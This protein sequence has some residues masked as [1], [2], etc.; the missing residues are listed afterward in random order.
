MVVD[1]ARTSGDRFSLGHLLCA[2]AIGLPE[3]LPWWISSWFG[4]EL[5]IVAG[6]TTVE[7]EVAGRTEL[8]CLCC[9]SFLVWGD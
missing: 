4:A 7:T 8:G 1:Q 9:L 2:D 5:S 6:L 3:L